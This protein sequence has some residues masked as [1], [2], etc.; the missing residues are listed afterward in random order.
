MAVVFF[1]TALAMSV[2]FGTALLATLPSNAVM[3]RSDAVRL[4]LLFNVVASQG[5]GFFTRD[6]QSEQT[7]AYRVL[8]DGGVHS[9]LITP[10]TRD[11]NLYGL[12]RR[13]RAQGPELAALDRQLSHVWRDCD[14]QILESCVTANTPTETLELKNE[15]PIP[16]ICG[17]VIFTIEHTTKWSYRDLTSNRY[18]VFKFARSNVKCNE[19]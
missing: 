1:V 6:P 10:Q 15:S 12:S 11:R 14:S 19:S 13:Q 5:F 18:T 16:T 8:P 17:D 2:F 4:K 3:G 9:L 7:D